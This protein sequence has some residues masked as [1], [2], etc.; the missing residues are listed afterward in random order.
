MIHTSYDGHCMFSLISPAIIFHDQQMEPEKAE[1]SSNDRGNRDA[2]PNSYS[3]GNQK[4]LVFQ[5][6]NI[7]PMPNSSPY[8]RKF[9]LQP[10]P[11]HKRL[12]SKIRMKRGNRT[13]ESISDPQLQQSSVEGARSPTADRI[14]AVSGIVCALKCSV[15]GALF[16]AGLTTSSAG[17]ISSLHSVAHSPIT[18]LGLTFVS[19]MAAS[20]GIIYPYYRY[21]VN[22]R[23]VKNQTAFFLGMGA[24]AGV[25]TITGG[26]IFSGF[27]LS[28]MPIMLGSNMNDIHAL[29]SH[30]LHHSADLAAIVY[31]PKGPFG[32]DS[33]FFVQ[34]F[35]SSMRTLFFL[36][37]VALASL[38]ILNLWFH[39]V[40]SKRCAS[41]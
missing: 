22:A 31:D 24:F 37:S 4:I 41:S 18:V 38:H 9:V 15:V 5:D 16:A 26:L 13:W 6:N 36:S 11:L 32:L 25:M 34:L 17:L 21:L 40:S 10:R 29:H 7:Q 14:G 23:T 19:A 39:K 27:S 8:R 33:N 2:N 12:L 20:R 35:E 30:G 1:P 3:V 28:A